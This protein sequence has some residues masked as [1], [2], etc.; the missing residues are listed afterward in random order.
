MLTAIA[1]LSTE[2]SP[3]TVSVNNSS[4]PAIVSESTAVFELGLRFMVT[5]MPFLS[6]SDENSARFFETNR[7]AESAI[8]S[9]KFDFSS[10]F[11]ATCEMAFLY[12]ACAYQGLLFC[13][14]T[15]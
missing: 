15:S 13:A 14:I 10:F 12:A 6:V 2:L 1:S 5:G 4:P 11:L 3:G 8:S 7:C 9:S